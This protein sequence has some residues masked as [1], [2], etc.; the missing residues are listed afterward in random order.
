MSGE[1]IFITG[2][3]TGIGKTTAALWLLDQLN[4]QGHSTIAIKPVA[5]GCEFI[6]GQLINDDA[7]KL[8]QHA[9]IKL[10]YS[11]VN[12]FAFAPPIAPHLAALE[13]NQILSAEI[14]SE[15]IAPTLKIP[16]DYYVIEGCG[17]WLVPLNNNETYADFVVKNDFSVILVVGMRLGC[18]NHALLTYHAI[19]AS[20]V[21]LKGWIANCIDPTMGYREHNI[22]SLQQIIAEPCLATMDYIV[23]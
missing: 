3:D 17:G 1:K 11:Q 5:S 23:L 2:T 7:L 21:K 10:A 9:S 13:N 20:G 16:A 8:Q 18:L 4:Q 12:P 15:A 6:N 22:K 14:I 19:K